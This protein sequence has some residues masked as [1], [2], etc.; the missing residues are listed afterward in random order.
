MKKILSIIA[1][2]IA[3][4][5][6]GGKTNLETALIQAGDNRA[7]LEKVLNHYAVD[8]LK[9]KAACFLIENMPSLYCEPNRRNPPPEY[10]TS[11]LSYQI[12][13][14][15]S[16]GSGNPQSLRATKPFHEAS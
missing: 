6:C 10:H 3:V 1:L 15:F 11:T 5:A 16:H 9:Y 8:S 4:M 2:S 12:V 7:E 13:R 14:S